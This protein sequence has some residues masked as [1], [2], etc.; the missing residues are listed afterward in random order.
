MMLLKIL[1]NRHDGT[2]RAAT[3]KP[4]MSPY[5]P[6]CLGFFKEA[7]VQNRHLK[8]LLKAFTHHEM[9]KH[10]IHEWW[11]FFI[12]DILA[13]MGKKIETPWS[14]YQ[15]EHLYKIGQEYAKAVIALPPFYD[16]LGTL[17]MELS[18]KGSS[19]YLA[20]YFT[21]MP[22]AQMMTKMTMPDKLPE[23]K[24]IFRIYEPATGSGV[25]VLSALA[26]FLE[27]GE[28]QLHKISITAND[29]DRICCGMTTAQIMA[30]LHIHQLSLGEIFI[31]HGNTL[32][33]PEDLSIFY[34]A[35]RPDYPTMSIKVLS[36]ILE[37]N[38]AEIQRKIDEKKSQLS[39]F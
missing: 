35:A 32:G 37:A 23:E 24:N 12:K 9:N 20:Q 21:P 8:D 17:Y 25:M 30:N 6:V 28:D 39:L 4:L 5:V 19:K 13:G 14:E 18:S 31:T 1:R 38:K 29:L 10:R 22:I 34:H 33:R 2:S 11:S 26:H 16:I 36:N 15:K 3:L 27:H 7:S